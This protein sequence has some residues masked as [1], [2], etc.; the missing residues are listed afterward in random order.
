[1]DQYKTL[2]GILYGSLNN[3]ESSTLWE[4]IPRNCLAFTFDD[5]FQQTAPIL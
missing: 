4:Q 2:Y 5:D 1:M 3:L